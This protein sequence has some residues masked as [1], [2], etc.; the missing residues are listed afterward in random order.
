[1]RSDDESKAILDEIAAQRS[2]FSKAPDAFFP[3]PEARRRTGRP[4]PVGNGTHRNV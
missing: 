3:T 2:A 1:M 4:R